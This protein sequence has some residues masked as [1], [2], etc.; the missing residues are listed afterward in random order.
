MK[1]SPCEWDI[2]EQ[3]ALARTGFIMY[4]IHMSCVARTHYSG[5]QV[6]IWGIPRLCGDSCGRNVYRYLSGGVYSDRGLG[7]V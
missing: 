1:E 5:W 6:R 4:N 3:V 2:A 7:M